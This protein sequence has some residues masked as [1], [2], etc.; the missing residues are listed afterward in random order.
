[1]E[2]STPKTRVTGHFKNVHAH[3]THEH[4][5]KTQKEV[6]LLQ[7]MNITHM[8]SPDAGVDKL[9]HEHEQVLN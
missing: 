3:Y 7:E 8:I 1:M 6:K 4:N 2:I 5:H 9:T